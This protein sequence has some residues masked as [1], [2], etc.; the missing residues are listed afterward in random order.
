MT[1]SGG[2]LPRLLSWW[3]SA[4]LSVVLVV[5]LLP[6]QG[7]VAS[8]K[9]TVKA[10]DNDVAKA[11]DSDA[12]GDLDRPD[13][14]SASITARLAK[15]PVEDLSKRTETN[16]TMVNPDGTL[17]D[18]VF[19]TAV[20]VRRGD[21]WVDVDYDLVERDG[22][23]FAPKAASQDVVVGGGGSNEAARIAFDDGAS[24]AV[25]WPGDLPVPSIQ[26]GVAT[27]RVSETMDVLVSITGN[28]VA[29]RI[30]LNEAPGAGDR[31]FAL[32]LKAKNLNVK[33]TDAGGLS[34][35][36]GDGK[37]MGTTST[38]VAWDAKRDAAG[39]PIVV[40]PVEADLQRIAGRGNDGGYGLKLGVPE[41]FLDDPE[42]EYP[43]IIDPDISAVAH[44]RDTWVRSSVSTPQ[45]GSAYLV[46]G[47][48]SS[49]S[50]VNPGLVYSQWQNAQLAGKTI[51]KAEMGLYQYHSG[52]CA[53]RSM[54]VQPLTSD[55]TEASTVYSNRPSFSST[56]GDTESITVNRGGSG[57]AAG[58]GFT[59]VDIKHMVQKWAKGPTNS[60]YTN[61]GLQVNVPRPVRLM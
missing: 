3:L 61:H 39:D 7:A 18:E 60:G 44:W 15:M 23:S 22:G 33:K 57:C 48:S 59:T 36:D 9:S 29:T 32:G 1:Q 11:D 51:I 6:D 16:R 38:L 4:F 24:L 42:T 40:V 37:T 5:A 46:L 58:D 47:R 8:V 13:G 30:R 53:A 50:S 26:G 28:G 21:V 31:V 2:R 27:Y 35:T 19:G 41:G 17:T 14:V 54:Y 10:A 12:D 49:S 25:E 43:V 34:V 20:R 55:F 45:G 56:T 52:T